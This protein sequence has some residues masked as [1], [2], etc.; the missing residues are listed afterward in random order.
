VSVRVW[1]SEAASTHEGLAAR[2]EGYLDAALSEA[3]GAVE[4]DVVPRPVSIP[5]EDGRRVLATH[6]PAKVIKG[7]VGMGDVD[8]VDGVNLLVTDGDPREQPA[9][10]GRPR[11]AAA[12]GASYVARMA[13][14]SET[15][16]VVPYSIRAATTQLLLHEVG[17]ALGAKHKHGLAR[18]RDGALVASPM[19]GSYLWAAEDVRD[20]HLPDESACGDPLPKKSDAPKRRLR[21]RYADCATRALE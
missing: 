15:N 13:P 7:A 17:H 1:L 12:T 6:W 20:R 9:G 10:Y 5:A 18:R 16:D 4:I 11:V 19:V 8:P 21:L 3:V 2:I 14:A